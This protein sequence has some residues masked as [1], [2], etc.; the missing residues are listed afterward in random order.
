MISTATNMTLLVLV[1]EQKLVFIM[2]SKSIFFFVF[3]ISFS[4]FIFRAGK[5]R[6]HIWDRGVERVG[7]FLGGF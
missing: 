4:V 7:F 5:V 2:R 3:L 1:Q 6:S